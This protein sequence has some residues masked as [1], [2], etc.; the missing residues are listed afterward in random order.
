MRF[1]RFCFFPYRKVRGRAQDG[2]APVADRRL[3][4]WGGLRPHQEP[5][6]S[7]AETGADGGVLQRGAPYSPPPPP[8]L[9]PPPTAYQAIACASHIFAIVMS[10]SPSA[11]SPLCLP[12]RSMPDHSRVHRSWHAEVAERAGDGPENAAAAGAKVPR[13]Q[14][15]RGQHD[16][17]EASGSVDCIFLWLAWIW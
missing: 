5:N 13:V 7:S 15:I 14:G 16:P 6:G 10:M 8:P 17:G 9:A 1:V 4:A 2:A 12:P 3:Q 11:S